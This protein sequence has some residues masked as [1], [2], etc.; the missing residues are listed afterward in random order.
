MFHVLLTLLIVGSFF[1]IPTVTFGQTPTCT[2]IYGGGEV[3]CTKNKSA[4]PTLTT[5]PAQ[6]ANP[7][8]TKG[9]LPVY[10]SQT[11]TT[12]PATGPETFAL[13]SMIPV[14]LAGWYLRKKA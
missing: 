7:P 14:A 5:S 13:I 10:D 2:I 4:T 12:T 1:L 6:P 8:Q 3:D 9:G 11:A